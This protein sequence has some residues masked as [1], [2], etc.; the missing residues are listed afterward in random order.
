[1]QG[2]ECPTSNTGAVLGAR[3]Q[4]RPKA[5]PE[6]PKEGHEDSERLTAPFLGEQSTLT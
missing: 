4:K 6:Y 1:M 3:M 5:L 2:G